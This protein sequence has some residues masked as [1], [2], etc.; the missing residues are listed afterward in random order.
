MSDARSRGSRALAALAFAAGLAAA[1]PASA[2]WSVSAN[3]GKSV[4]SLGFLAQMQI[5]ALK[6]A[7]SDEYAQNLFVRRA[8][9]ILGGRV[10]ART[11]FFLDTDVPNLGKGQT[12]GAK[13][14][15][16]M[17]LQDLVITQAI[18]R[19]FKVDAGMLMVPVSHNAQQSV[20]SATPI[21]YGPYSFL[22]SD[23][24]DSRVNRDYGVD[25]RAYLAGQHAELR[26]GVYQGARGGRSIG[27]F[28]T[29]LRAVY[30]PFEAD[31]GFFYSG[32]GF[33]KK[34]I[35]A[36]GGSFDTQQS[37]ESWAGDLYVDWPVA[38]DCVNL[39]V[40]YMRCD[41]RQSFVALP[42]QDALLLEVGYFFHQAH[43]T[44][45]V[46][47]A[48]RDFNDPALADESKLQGGLAVWGNGHRHNLKL[49]VAKLTR[50]AAS[51]GLQYLAQ[52]QVL[53][54]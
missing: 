50:H 2:Q 8:R 12:T 46:Q 43:L 54:F 7:G 5:E 35:V 11:S 19:E 22:Q 28:R 9:L 14:S 44:P 47:F 48:T 4:L 21:D 10:D 29:T 6:A 26:A 53:A 25:G 20:A 41:G 15:N 49:G 36:L 32:T 37:Y 51:D 23:A 17:V 45:F 3:D 52:W 16:T 24:T 33:G 39:Q 34:R 40:D 18:G 30:Y 13:V 1:A 42:R 31:T 38:G 27:A